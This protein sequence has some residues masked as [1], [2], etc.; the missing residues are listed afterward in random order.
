VPE[1]GLSF[2]WGEPRAGKEAAAGKAFGEGEA[3][4]AR[5]PGGGEI[6]SFETVVLIAIGA[7]VGSKGRPTVCL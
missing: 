4:L 1:F 7:A 2:G 5:A 6:E 3:W